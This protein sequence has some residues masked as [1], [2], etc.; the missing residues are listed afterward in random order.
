MLPPPTVDY[1]GWKEWSGRSL[2]ADHRHRDRWLLEQAMST[3]AQR[4]RWPGHCALCD[5]GVEF[6]L[7][8]RDGEADFREEMCC[9]G[10]GLNARV[11]A[12]LHL[13]LAG[14]PEGGR[15]Y[16]TEQASRPFVWLQ[17]R[18][19]AV[20]GSEFTTDPERIAELGK[21]LNGPLGGH[22]EIRFEDVTRL[23]MEDASLDAVASFDVLEHVPDYR[24]ALAEFARV[25]KPGGR[26]V[27][28]APFIAAHEATL[29][30]ARID[31]DGIDHLLEPEYH[32]DP[33][34]GGILCF[35]HFGW[36]LLD[37]ARAAGFTDA[38]M[39][40]PWAPG[41]GYCGALWTLV[42]TR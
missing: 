21:M 7:A 35:F 26:L 15:V 6:S 41:L 4:E 37:E 29:V 3:L 33:V 12:G 17:S 31:G 5:R 23:G 11:R 36:D 34:A 25:L 24:A 28:T 42:A 40:L 22:G 39:V 38:R 9:P 32:G 13:L 18:G 16:I 2:E 10:C 19:V 14:L 30:R 27:L 1:P 8:A 20:I